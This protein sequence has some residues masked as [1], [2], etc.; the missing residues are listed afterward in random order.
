[1]LIF[2]QLFASYNFHYG[3]SNFPELL[4]NFRKEVKTPTLKLLKP[5][6]FFLN[7]S[8]VEYSNTCSEGSA[9]LSFRM[10]FLPSRHIPKQP[11]LGFRTSAAN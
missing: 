1:M 10:P 3:N 11:F 2:C 4:L 9:V 5:F 6:G 7:L 8:S